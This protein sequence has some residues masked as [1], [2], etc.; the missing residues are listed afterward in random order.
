MSVGLP[1]VTGFP[2]PARVTF[3]P[4]K[5]MDLKPRRIWP[6]AKSPRRMIVMEA[7]NPRP[8]HLLG[9][10]VMIFLR[11]RFGKA[12]PSTIKWRL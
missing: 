6:M 10:A 2:K 8:D 9:L 12:R 11:Q 7:P 5:F 4:K 3:V 1:P